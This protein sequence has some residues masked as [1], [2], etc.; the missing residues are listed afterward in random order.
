MNLF[1][2]ISIAWALLAASFGLLAA[3]VL[4]TGRKKPT[5]PE[6][7]YYEC[8]HCKALNV[9]YDD[10]ECEFQRFSDEIHYYLNGGE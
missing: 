2:G 4:S 3:A 5:E 8:R 7:E 6:Q 10:C 1:T 9:E